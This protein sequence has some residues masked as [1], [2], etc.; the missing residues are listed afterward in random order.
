MIYE[1]FKTWIDMIKDE[2]SDEKY[3]PINDIVRTVLFGNELTETRDVQLDFDFFERLVA[4]CINEKNF[5][6]RFQF[7]VLYCLITFVF[8]NSNAQAEIN[9]TCVLFGISSSRASTYQT[10]WLLTNINERTKLVSS[11]RTNRFMEN[12]LSPDV[13]PEMFSHIA[14]L[15]LKCKY[16]EEALIFWNYH[17]PLLFSTDDIKTNI[18][19]LKYN[20]KHKEA[21][22]LVNEVYFDEKELEIFSN[23]L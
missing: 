22:E 23:F 21:K 12:I 7:S 18:R 9:R 13:F 1:P 2:V 6:P 3:G 20:G 14:E 17:K 8:Y 16:Y 15:L 4:K 5:N 10:I 19:I 11:L